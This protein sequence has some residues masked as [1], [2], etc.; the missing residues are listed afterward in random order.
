[1]KRY[2]DRKQA[3]MKSMGKLNRNAGLS[4][5]ELLVA[6]AV[7]AIVISAVTVLIMQG[8]NS[9]RR[10]T[11]TAQLQE[12]AAIAMNHIS[13][14]IMEATCIMVSNS[15]SDTG[16]TLSFKLSEA[17]SYVYQPEQKV[18]YVRTAVLGEAGHT[19]S[20]LCQNVTAFKVQITESSVNKK[21]TSPGSYRISSLNNPVQVK[22]TIEVSSGDL[23]RA[24]TRVTGVRNMLAFDQVTLGGAVLDT[25]PVSEVLNKYGFLTD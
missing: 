16:S 7:S 12:D 2:R 20:V 6:L 23:S 15:D 13:D 22:V 1:M 21:E 3:Y 10:Q 4:L 24:V 11:L 9:Y 5:I 17:H 8:T 25:L 19:D 18:L 14:S